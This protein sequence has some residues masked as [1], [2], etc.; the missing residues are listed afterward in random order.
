MGAENERTGKVIAEKL[1]KYMEMKMKQK[2]ETLDKLTTKNTLL[3]KQFIKADA[4]IKNKVIDI[5][6]YIIYIYIYNILGGHG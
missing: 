5:L 1:E 2:D 3:K 6:I 4:Q